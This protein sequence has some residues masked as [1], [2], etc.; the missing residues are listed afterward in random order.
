M[1][2]DRLLKVRVGAVVVVCYVATFGM[3]MLATGHQVLPLFESISPQTTYA[4]VNP[5]PG[6]AAT[7]SKPSPSQADVP[8]SGGQ[9]EATAL[10]SSDNQFNVNVAKGAI[11]SHGADEG[12]AAITPLD[13]ATLGALP[14]GLCPNGNTYRIVLTYKPSNVAIAQLASAGDV[15]V[16][17][18]NV[19]T[20]LVYSPDAKT[21][22]KIASQSVGTPMT[23]GATTFTQGGYYLATAAPAGGKCHLLSPATGDGA[24]SSGT[25][26]VA[27]GIGVGAVALG[28][29]AF[30]LARPRHGQKTQS[31]RGKHR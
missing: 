20:G 9:S 26:L 23:V 3:T 17:G 25:L 15:I 2:D 7:N 30:A 1:A 18:P 5:P 4:W 27:L 21:W 14:A 10:T 13:P 8:F 12:H 16:T 11:A 24:G 6:A 29:G 31:P 28:L 19:A 22:T